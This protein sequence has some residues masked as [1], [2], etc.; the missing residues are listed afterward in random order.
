ML[1]ASVRIW[2]YH[3]VAQTF[4]GSKRGSESREE[5]KDDSRIGRRSTSRI[6]VSVEQIRQVIWRSLV[7]CLTERESAGGEKS[8][9]NFGTYLKRNV[10][11]RWVSW[12]RETPLYWNNLPIQLFGLCGIFFFSPSSKKPILKAWRPSRRL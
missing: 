2:S 4:L 12:P 8:V 5:V 1:T 11:V 3:H 6:Q 9:W 10:T 7:V